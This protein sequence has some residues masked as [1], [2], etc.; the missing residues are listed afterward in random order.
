MSVTGCS[1][2]SC[3]PVTAAVLTHR[4][5]Y[6]SIDERYQALG[7]WVAHHGRPTGAPVREIY[8]VGPREVDDPSAY[9]TDICW[10][11]ELDNET[12]HQHR[13]GN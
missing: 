13:E 9:R 10:P 6:D 11:V 5:S 1:G 8:V 12:N 2:W 4:G 7:A 3:P